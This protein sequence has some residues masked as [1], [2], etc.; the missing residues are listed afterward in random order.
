MGNLTKNINRW[1]LACGCG[2]GFDS[3]DWETIEVLQI[4]CDNFA[5]VLG[6]DKVFLN[7]HSA[8]RC[9]AYN[10]RIGGSFESQHI[11]ARAVDFSIVDINPHF[12]WSFLISRY[13]G[14][15][16]IG[17]YETFT[18]LDTRSLGPARW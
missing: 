11:Q 13:N 17:K 10:Q 15:F 9:V 1:E 4:C 7:I 6:V 5:D 16:G 3:V 8:A 18:H 12:V 2:C 14:K